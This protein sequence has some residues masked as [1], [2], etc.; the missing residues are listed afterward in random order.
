MADASEY[1]KALL[2]LA[3]ESGNADSVLA[4][5]SD[6]KKAIEDNPKYVDLADTPALPS[7]KR[8]ELIHEAF[9]GIDGNLLNLLKILCEKREFYKV[10]AVADSFGKYYD[11]SVGRL[12]V[13]AVTAVPLTSGQCDA[14]VKR[15]EAKTGKTVVLENIVDPAVLGGVKLRYDGVQY[16]GTLR[17]NLLSMEK[18]LAELKL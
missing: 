18:S 11:E 15:L 4:D 6:V 2:M 9:S 17:A 1:G 14:L 12:R 10:Y 3:N 8:V 7:S 16:D 5:F 13:T